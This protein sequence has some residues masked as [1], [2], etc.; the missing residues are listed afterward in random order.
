MYK[1]IKIHDNNSPLM[2]VNN[3]GNKSSIKDGKFNK[4]YK[5]ITKNL[6]NVSLN[7]LKNRSKNPTVLSL[8]NNYVTEFHLVKYRPKRLTKLKDQG[9]SQIPITEMGG[10]S[11]ELEKVNKSVD[12]NKNFNNKTGT[13]LIDDFLNNKT[14]INNFAENEFKSYYILKFAKISED[15]NKLKNFDEIMSDNMNKR[16]FDEYFEKISKLIETQNKLYFNNIEYNQ[17][18]FNINDNIVNNNISP[19]VSSYNSIIPS[20]NFNETTKNKTRNNLVQD[21]PNLFSNTSNNLNLTKYNSLNNTYITT[22]SSFNSPNFNNFTKNM[23]SL[24]STWAEIMINF[25]KFI[26][27][28]LKEIS[29]YKTDNLNLK[30]K[31][32]SDETHLNKV[33]RELDELKKYINKFDINHKI[34]SQMH[35]ENKINDLKKGFLMKENE[36]K[37][38][39]YKLEKEIKALTT[40]LD[41]NKIYYTKYLDLSKEIGINRKEKEMLKVKFNKELQENNIQFLVEKDLKEELNLKIEKLND[42][43]KGINEE[44]NEEKRNNVEMQ[45]LIKKLRNEMVEK[46][47][48]IMMLNEELEIYI[49]KYYEEKSKYLTTLKDLKLLEIKVNKENES[50]NTIEKEKENEN[51]GQNKN[52]DE[53]GHDTPKFLKNSKSIKRIKKIDDKNKSDTENFSQNN[54][55]I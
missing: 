8:G 49:R 27:H 26:A 40:L 36:Y 44:K 19:K 10:N 45:S 14:I 42:E 51:N 4:K 33:S 31:N 22:L 2:Q 41:N 17:N 43:L 39:I 32:V 6:K 54:N 55:K 1:S 24:F 13:N 34:Y 35:K 25:T 9:N 30:K 50:K 46:K 15:F 18:S 28:I 7:I 21:M 47:E 23:K 5:I 3:F 48:N 11:F 38:T 20:I 16:I 52:K 29:I 53:N 37:L 12:K